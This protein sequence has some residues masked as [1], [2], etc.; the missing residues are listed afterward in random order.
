MPAYT[1]EIETAHDVSR[2][3]G[4]SVSQS[5]TLEAIGHAEDLSSIVTNIDPDKT[6]FLS[7]FDNEPDAVEL[8]F[9]WMTE[10]L[11]P[12][13][14]NAHLEKEDYV[15]GPVG[16]MEGLSNH[17][18]RF[19]N[20]GWVTTAQIKVKKIYSQQ[21]EFTR[22]YDKAFTEHASDIEYMLVNS[23]ISCKEN[24]GSRTY[25][26]T[27]ARSGGV[28]F[29]MQAQTLAAT[30]ETTGGVVDSGTEKHGLRTGDFVYFTAGTMPDGMEANV[31]YYVRVGATDSDTTTA[32]KKFRIF[33]TQKGAVEGIAAEQIIPTTAGSG[34]KIV[35]N[36]VIDLGGTAFDLDSLNDVMQM[37]Y[38]RGGNPTLAVMSPAKKRQFSSLVTA[39][40]Q[41]NRSMRKKERALDIVANV[42]ETDFGVITAKAH[43]M[44][45]DNRI[46]MM[47]MN[48]WGL[49]WFERTH[50]IAGIAT[51]G[52]YKEFFMESWLGLKGTQ[53]KASG[54]LINVAR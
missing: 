22:Q 13:A 7:E 11:R 37:C 44:Y 40:T 41:I 15:S 52:S 30:V 28:P 10:G 8:D 36:N 48:Y 14:D 24:E 54:S 26:D 20:G 42:L 2:N 34:L 18:Q 51:K 6:F 49:K 47:D 4:P 12:P 39:Q 21:N 31:L 46:D 53:P 19:V 5:H 43:R 45:P 16:S 35:K 27:P 25:G 3:L 17:C 33:L 50:E 1:K 38:Y 29:F 23:T 32:D 9:S